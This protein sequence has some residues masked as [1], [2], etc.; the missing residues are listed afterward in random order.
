MTDTNIIHTKRG[1]RVP[2]SEDRLWAIGDL[3]AWLH[4]GESTAYRLAADPGFPRCVQIGKTC[5]R[6][7][8]DEVKRW[9]ERQRG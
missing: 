6:W 5:R 1:G 7:I 9:V 2:P 8:P 3:A 4:V